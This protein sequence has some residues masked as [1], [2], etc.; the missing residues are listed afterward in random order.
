MSDVRHDIR[1]YVLANVLRED[2]PLALPDDLDLVQAGVLTSLPLMKLVTFVETHFDIEVGVSDPREHFT[3]VDQLV[4]YIDKQ[5]AGAG[6]G[7]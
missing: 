6:H 5:R 1:G 3:S 7:E 4:A 2:D